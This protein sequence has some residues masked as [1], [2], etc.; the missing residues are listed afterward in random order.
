MKCHVRN[1]FTGFIALL[2]LAGCTQQQQSG[3]NEQDIAKVREEI[4]QAWRQYEEAWVKGDA[5]A[6]AGWYTEDAINM[7]PDFEDAQGRS[8]I[9]GAFSAILS[10]ATREDITFTARE[11]DVYEDTAYELGTFVDTFVPHSGDKVTFRGRY[12][13][14]WKRQPDGAWK[15]HRFLFNSLPPPQQ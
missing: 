8:E 3:M 5:A 12:M 4:S 14:V 9:Q 15:I 6:A 10:S 2:L 7:P 11:L 13:C 1:F